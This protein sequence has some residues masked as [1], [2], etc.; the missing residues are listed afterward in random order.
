MYQLFYYFAN[1]AT[2]IAGHKLLS[3]DLSPNSSREKLV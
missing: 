2:S 3:L 1:F